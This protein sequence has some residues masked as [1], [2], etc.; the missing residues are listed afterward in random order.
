MRESE[1]WDAHSRLIA[2]EAAPETTMTAILYTHSEAKEWPG[3]RWPF[4]QKR[5]VHVALFEPGSARAVLDVPVVDPE[6]EVPLD[7]PVTVLVRGQVQVGHPLIVKVG[8][9]EL[10]SSSP[11]TTARRYT[12]RMTR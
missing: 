6:V 10:I 7:Q 8:D 3:A 11:P 9:V 5:V 4:N 2:G 1:Y 12:P